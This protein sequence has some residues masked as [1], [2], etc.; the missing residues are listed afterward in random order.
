[1]THPAPLER[2]EILQ[3]HRDL[4][5]IP[6]V[7]HE[8]EAI[9]QFMARYL[10]DRGLDVEVIGN[11]VL[12]GNLTAPRLLLNTHLDTVPPTDNWIRNPF[13]A[14]VEDGKVFGLGSNDALASVVAMTAATLRAA[15]SNTPAMPMLTLV[16]DEETGGDGTE[17][18]LPELAQRNIFLEG[19]VVGEPTELHIA[20]AQRGMLVLRLIAEG[21]VCHSANA[22][23][24]GA[25]NAIT[26][27]SADITAATSLDLGPAD[28]LLG[29]TSLEPTLL[30]AGGARN[31]LAKEATAILDIRSAPCDGWD[32]DRIINA[33]RSTVRSKVEVI[34]KR[35]TSQLYGS[36]TMSDMVFF[37]NTPTI[38]VGPGLSDRSHTPDEFVFEA[39]IL[40]GADFYYSLIDRFA[41]MSDKEK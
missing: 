7:S 31:A 5:E 26:T 23:A 17:L 41:A 21:T 11:N 35:P 4:I 3:L 34:S 6:S 15:A 20:M 13:K 14:T 39:E 27:L 40:E 29:E 36:R 19:V 10:S 18:I 38:K 12:A 28:D 32:H 24:L 33:V 37:P 22:R 25:V 8:E 30:E 2:D 16:A 9:V 1:M